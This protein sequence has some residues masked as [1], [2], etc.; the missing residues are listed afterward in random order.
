[1]T[2]LLT[3]LA[4]MAA[5]ALPAQAHRLVIYAFVE[6]NEVVV[7]T[8]FSTGKLPATGSITATDEAG[9]TVVTLDLDPGGETRF[10]VPQGHTGGMQITV[11]TG[12]GHEDYWVLTDQDFDPEGAE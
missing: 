7:E 6:G 5:C 9:A 2:R 10:A 1:M 4:L 3:A 12:E 8:K 11:I